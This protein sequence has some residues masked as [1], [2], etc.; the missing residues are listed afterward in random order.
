M[1]S[2]PTPWPWAGTF[3]SM[4]LLR[5]PSNLTL[6][7]SRDEVSTRIGF[8]PFH[9]S[10]RPVT[11]SPLLHSSSL[12]RQ[13]HLGLNCPN[14]LPLLPSQ[15]PRWGLQ[16]SLERTLVC[17]SVEGTASE[18]QDAASTYLCFWWMGCCL[19]AMYWVSSCKRF[20]GDSGFRR[21]P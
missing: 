10:V 17:G 7:V 15:A 13:Q 18:L 5:A 11:C 1:P 6:N 19:I 20:S 21:I 4:R 8:G 9:H 12:A 14:T 16:L 2:S 3:Y